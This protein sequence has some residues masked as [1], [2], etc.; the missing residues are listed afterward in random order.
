[1][2]TKIVF[3]LITVVVVIVGCSNDR[4]LSSEEYQLLKPR[5]DSIR[6]N[7]HKIDLNS[8]SVR[9]G[10]LLI[11]IGDIRSLY[12]NTQIYYKDPRTNLYFSAVVS[13]ATYGDVV[14]I[15]LVP[16]DSL[17]NVTVYILKP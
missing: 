10:G 4:T 11:T 2:K 8:L 15:T 17:K 9:D 16:A 1:M 3:L 7:S 6:H 14:S 12:S 5:L 13:E